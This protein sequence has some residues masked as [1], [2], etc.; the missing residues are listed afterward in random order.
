MS[1]IS[2]IFVMNYIIHKM[3]VFHIIMESLSLKEDII[4]KDNLFG[5]KRKELNST[6]IEDLRNLFR[7]KKKLKKLKIK[8]LENRKKFL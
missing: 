3:L 1:L 8:F 2:F 6:I 7:Q 4:N 5:L